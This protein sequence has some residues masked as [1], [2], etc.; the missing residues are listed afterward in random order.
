MV[1]ISD[2]LN[3]KGQQY[4]AL[5]QEALFRM[6]CCIPAVVQS[7]DPSANTVSCQ[8]TIRE[9]LNLPNGGTQ[10]VNLPLLINVPVMFPGGMGYSLKFPIGPGDEV[11]VFFSDLSLDNFWEKGNVQ[12]PV[13]QRRHDLSDGLAFPTNIS[14]PANNAI[15]IAEI[16]FTSTD[17]LFKAGLNST[18]LSTLISSGGGTSDHTQLTNRDAN[19][20]HPISAITHLQTNLD[21]LVDTALTYQDILDVVNQ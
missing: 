20:Q 1:N 11:L 6:R 4:E 17:I 16:E 18:T 7:Y 15:K 9:K 3:E 8:P 12:N 10:Y 19:E 5:I 21:N 13:E 14:V 2:W